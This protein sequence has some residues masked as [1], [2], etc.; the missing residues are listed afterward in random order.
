MKL[1]FFTKIV[2]FVT[3]AR[4]GV[5]IYIFSD[6]NEFLNYFRMS[7]ISSDEMVNLHSVFHPCLF[8]SI[9]VGRLLRVANG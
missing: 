5:I 8:L 9:A 1:K 7:M 4:V 3:C 6:E 2:L